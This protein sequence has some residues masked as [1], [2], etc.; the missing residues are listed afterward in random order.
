MM[1]DERSRNMTY[2]KRLKDMGLFSLE[3]RRERR[4]LINLGIYE[5]LS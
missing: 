3:K 1:T 5:V 2:K 4:D